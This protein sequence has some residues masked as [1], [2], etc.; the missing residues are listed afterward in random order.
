MANAL[1]IKDLAERESRV[2]EVQRRE[3]EARTPRMPLPVLYPIKKKDR[4][5]PKPVG[6][7]WKE[8]SKTSSGPPTHPDRDDEGDAKPL[9]E[10]VGAFY[11]DEYEGT[12]RRRHARGD[13]LMTSDEED[14]DDENDDAGLAVRCTGLSNFPLVMK[15]W[16]QGEQH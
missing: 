15:V 9:N 10:D 4:V 6:G 2:A 5:V 12:E 8:Q 11:H 16:I 13:L 3:R 1:K 7:T 14:E